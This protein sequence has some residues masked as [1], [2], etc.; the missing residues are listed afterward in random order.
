MTPAVQNETFVWLLW[1][2]ILFRFFFIYLI[3][4]AS[5]WYWLNSIPGIYTVTEWYD[6]LINWAVHFGKKFR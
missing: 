3:L 2:K 4:Q 5:P 6:N 1:K